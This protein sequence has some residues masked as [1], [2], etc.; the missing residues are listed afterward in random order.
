MEC[1]E[2]GILFV[3]AL[4][5]TIIETEKAL[6]NG[7][8]MEKVYYDEMIIKF[9]ATRLFVKESHNIIK[10]TKESSSS[11]DDGNIPGTSHV[12]NEGRAI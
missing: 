4:D 8:E 9:Q 12:R 1:R 10:R 11:S 6:E 3:R 2:I 7:A 5:Q